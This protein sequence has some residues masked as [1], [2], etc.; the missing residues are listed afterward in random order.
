M[1]KKATKKAVKK[2]DTAFYEEASS[3][4]LAQQPAEPEG[5]EP[6]VKGWG[7]L[8]GH[9]ESQIV[10]LRAWR[11]SW[12]TQNWSDLANFLLPR[13]SIWLTQSTGGMPSPN[14][15]TRGREINQ[16]IVDP[17]GTY[18]LRICAAGLMSGLA[19]PSRPW[20]KMKPSFKDVEIDSAGRAWLD[21]T[22][23]RIYTVLANSNFYNTF[24]QE[25]ED[26]T[27]FGTAP[28]IIY[29][30]EKEVIR[31][32]NPVIGEYYLSSDS[33]MRIDGLY[34]TFVFTV[35]QIV[36]FFGIENCPKTIRGLWAAK[37]AS[38]QTE[39]IVGHAIEP[40]FEIAGSPM[41]KLPDAF[42]WRETYWLWGQSNS[43]PLSIRGFV[44][45]PFT[46]ARWSTQ[47]NDAYGRSVGMDVLPDII[48][49]QVETRRKAEAIEKQVRPPLLASSALK[50]QPSSILPGAVTYVDK[51][52]PDEGMR[53][54]YNVNPDIGAMMNDLAAIQQRIQRGFFND[55]FLMLEQ[56]TGNMTATEVT[57]KIQ[58]KMQ[59]LGPVIE[60]LLSESLKPKL[61]RIYGIMKR[62]GLISEPPDSLKNVPLDLEFVSMLAIAQRAAATGGME[63]I[64]ALV[65]NLA[66]VFPHAVD[67]LDVD[68]FI[69]E[70]NM[71]LG[72]PA[73]ILF[74][75]EKIAA[76]RQQQQQAQQHATQQAT[77][78]QTAQTAQTGAQAAQ[79]LSQTQIGG[80]QQAL[81]A[82]L[83]N[84]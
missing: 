55:L 50:N 17:T 80:G 36:G 60:N 1:A 6:L 14:N 22:E 81:Q 31:C 7:S 77:M 74:G 56:G 58:E 70:M 83:G 26:L 10:Q 19:S 11:Q 64:A 20:F 33:T 16:S 41:S 29:E 8:K 37:G 25:C 82:V 66:P 35:Q 23:D 21:D 27:A 43:A 38:L 61:K 15:M 62:K 9:L 54:I 57:A 76:Q 67:N 49:L 46:A 24:A 13:R 78:A 69:N 12:W 45:S 51:L 68:T 30:D 40:N 28:N 18:A 4:L 79:V 39:F 3:T 34:R 2:F 63:R 75:P 5:K 65:G 48:Q 72:N 73:K 42:T 32:Y 71:M 84:S 47:S 52:G 59:V 53:S 44:E